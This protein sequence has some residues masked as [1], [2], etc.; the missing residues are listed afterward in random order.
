MAQLVRSY[1]EHAVKRT[2]RS[3]SALLRGR[4]SRGALSMLRDKLEPLG[5]LGLET[6]LARRD[7]GVRPDQPRL[8]A[9]MRLCTTQEWPMRVGTEHRFNGDPLY[10]DRLSVPLA[11]GRAGAN[12]GCQQAHAENPAR[13]PVPWTSPPSPS[14][15][16]RSPCLDSL[17]VTG[18]PEGTEPGYY[19]RLELTRREV[20]RPFIANTGH[21]RPSASH[22]IKTH[23]HPHTRSCHWTRSTSG[24]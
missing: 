22:G 16:R 7:C 13:G 10:S 17:L 8:S 24:Q 20:G 18:T 11:A 15:P 1:K 2:P 12:S 9:E 4:H 23:I 5:P 6:E 3:R 21:V 19:A 14:P